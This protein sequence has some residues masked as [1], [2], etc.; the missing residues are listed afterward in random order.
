MKDIRKLNIHA[1]FNANDE[2]Q[3]IGEDFYIFRQAS[4]RGQE[5]LESYADYPF[6]TDM[7]VCC[8]CLHGEATGRINL[9]DCTFNA[10]SMFI[11]VSRQILEVK[12]ISHDFM[13]ICILMSE[14]FISNLGLPF[15]FI[16]HNSVLQ[17]PVI[18]LTDRQFE[19][20]MNYCRMVH[21]VLEEGHPNCHEIVKHLT[22]AFF[23]GIGY[24]FHQA[25]DRAISND[26]ELMRRF[27]GEVEASYRHERQL[28]Y[29]ADRLHLTS[30]YLSSVVKNYSGKTASQWI[31][32]Y[33]I[34]E[35]KALLKSTNLTIQQISE[36]L[37]FP[38][39]SFFGKYFKR[40]TGRSPKE[41]RA[42]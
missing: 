8:L 1:L 3:R 22:C 24:Y 4:P 31:D 17:Q 39:Q 40:M 42:I 23:Y 16:V 33:V 18:R 32:D 30:K 27:L 10:K 21:R 37:S 26:E 7:T 38:S 35:A 11:S 15:N 12:S 36:E 9:S 2:V 19:A 34:L 6:K 5:G 20:M 29:Y 25:T 14:R 13:G 28:A 41:Y